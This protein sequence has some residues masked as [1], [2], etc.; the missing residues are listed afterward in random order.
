MKATFRGL[1]ENGKELVNEEELITY[2]F[3]F[4]KKLYMVEAMDDLV[5]ETNDIYIR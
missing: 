4:Y 3:G 2:I 1:I 5:L